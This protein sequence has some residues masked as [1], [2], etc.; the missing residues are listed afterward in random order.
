MLEQSAAYHDDNAVAPAGEERRA[1]IAAAVGTV[2]EWYDF[3]LYGAMTGVIAEKFFGALDPTLSF[4]FA[5]LTFSVGFLVRPLGALVFGRIGDMVGRKQSFVVTVTIMG[6]ATFLVG[7]LPTAE[8]IGVIAPTILISLRML[9]G[10]ALGGEYGGAVIYVCEHSAPNRRGF[11]TAWIQLTAGMGLL[12]SLL[13]ILVVRYLTGAAF[14]DWGWRIPFLLSGPLLVASLLIRT[15]MSESRTF[16]KMKEEGRLSKAPLREAFGTIDNLKRVAVALL[17]VT[18]SMSAVYYCALIYPM[19][20]MTQVLRAD[21][22]QVNLITAIAILGSLPMFVFFGW[23]SDKIGRRPLLLAS[24]ILTA[25]TVIPIFK[26]LGYYVN[27]A[28]STAHE[29]A[30]VRLFADESRCSFL[31]NPVGAAKTVTACDKARKALTDRGVGYTFHNT[32]G[33]DAVIDSGDRSLRIG[34]AD[35]GSATAVDGLLI[36]AGYP[37]AA[38][39]ARFN[40]PMATAMLLVLMMYMAM[41]YA[42]VAATLVEMFP[43]RIRYTSM[44]LPYNIS[45]GWVGGLLPTVTFALSAQKGNPYFGL[46]YTIVFASIG[47]VVM[48]FFYKERVG[49]DLAEV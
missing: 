36:E 9:Q 22:G 26:G 21:L 38:D 4:V 5:L 13:T 3:M 43:T 45:A 17:G 27:P 12:A 15:K 28:L 16:K 32:T 42:P 46:W 40:A 30:P 35:S 1:I 6:L 2:L 19:F 8:R 14:G 41:A 39:P 20:F 29:R 11:N 48:L 23:L 10:L 44:S 25:V 33:P 24:F 47:I 18:A 31:F 34:R 7:L 49:I 37:A